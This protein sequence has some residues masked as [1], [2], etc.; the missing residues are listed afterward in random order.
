MEHF[1]RNHLI[2]GQLSETDMTAFFLETVYIYKWLE[3]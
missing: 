2:L 3:T 1:G